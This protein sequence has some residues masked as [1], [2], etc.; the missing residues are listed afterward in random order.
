MALPQTNGQTH[1][2]I[3]DTSTKPE[4]NI[5]TVTRTAQNKKKQ[6]VE[7]LQKC[8]NTLF[9]NPVPSLLISI[10]DSFGIDKLSVMYSH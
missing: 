7:R 4:T 9:I 2:H 5:C 10:S 1:L 8:Y 6:E 3:K